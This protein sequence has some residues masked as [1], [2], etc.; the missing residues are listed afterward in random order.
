MLHLS[1]D[2]SSNAAKEGGEEEGESCQVSSIQKLS[3]Q[4]KL[5]NEFVSTWQ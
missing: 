5:R 1:V 4:K 3:I 2:E